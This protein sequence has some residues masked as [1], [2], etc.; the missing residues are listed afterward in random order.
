MPDPTSRP[1]GAD[2]SAALDDLE[3]NLQAQHALHE[4]LR[5]CLERTQEA[6][7]QAR[8]DDVATE[9]RAQHDIAQRLGD[10]EKTRLALIGTLTH[11]L[12]PE[13]ARI[14]SPSRSSYS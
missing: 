2:H 10:L 4:R 9:C 1:P 3:R 7:R 6:V 13:A 8:I 14:A 11:A 12:R 5:A